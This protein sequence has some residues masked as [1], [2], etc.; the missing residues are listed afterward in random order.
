MNLALSLL[1]LAAPPS[2]NIPAE[3]VATSESVTLQPDTD[4]KAITYIGLSGVDPFPAAFLKDPRSF[5]LPIRGLPNARYK[6]AA[7]ATLN[8]EQTRQDFVVVVGDA[9]PVPV[10]PVPPGPKP[11]E[12]TPPPVVAGK[13]ELMI[14]RE[15]AD[16]TPDFARTITA[17]QGKGAAYDYLRSKG[18]RIAILD[19]QSP[20]SVRQAWRPHFDG[21]TLPALVILDA[22]TRAL[23]YKGAISPTASAEEVIAK[24][25]EHGG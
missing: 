9:P 2:V 10:P 19:D 8:D 4:A 25:K 12:P 14:V 15:T 13:R 17:L 3:I 7:V 1:L 6:F 21:M 23:L 24:L 20:A 22:E 16:T 11:P 5:I 18:H